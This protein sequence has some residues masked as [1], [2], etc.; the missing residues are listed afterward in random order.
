[1]A[2]IETGEVDLVSREHVDA[3]PAS[4]AEAFVVGIAIADPDPDTVVV[5][6]SDTPA[7]VLVVNDVH[8]VG[9]IAEVDGQP[10]EVQRVNAL[11]RGVRVPEGAREVVLRF[12]PQD[13][14]STRT[15]W[16]LGWLL[17]LLGLAVPERKR[18]T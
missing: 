1:M 14:R 18:S 3:S 13:G 12:A 5:S 15:L 16:V 7:G 2:V 17:A 9:W 8:D 4:S 6:L 11:V 10:A